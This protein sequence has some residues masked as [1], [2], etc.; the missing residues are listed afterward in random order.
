MEIF[1][2]NLMSRTYSGESS[3]SDKKETELS[4]KRELGLDCALK[5][6]GNICYAI[7]SYKDIDDNLIGRYDL[8]AIVEKC[9]FLREII[10]SDPTAF[11]G[12]IDDLQHYIGNFEAGL[13]ILAQIKQSSKK[14]NI[15]KKAFKNKIRKFKDFLELQIQTGHGKET[16]IH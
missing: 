16:A 10:K 4:K 9:Q 5:K 11:Y 15:F 12:K 8:D 2:E 7:N 6:L 14:E 3:V 1:K 13:D